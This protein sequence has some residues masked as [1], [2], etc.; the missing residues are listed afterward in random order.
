MRQ[1]FEAYYLGR[2]PKSYMGRNTEGMRTYKVFSVQLAWEMW[3]ASRITLWGWIPMSQQRPEP[4]DSVWIRLPH[5]PNGIYDTHY[6]PTIWE[7]EAEWCP[8]PQIHSM[9]DQC[10]D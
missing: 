2:W 10:I 1:Q 5:E 7:D 6:D 8:R 3:C 4:G 9:H